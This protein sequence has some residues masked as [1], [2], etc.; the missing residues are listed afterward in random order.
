MFRL[1]SKRWFLRSD[2]EARQWNVE[3]GETYVC[4]LS[5]AVE[6]RSRRRWVLVTFSDSC[7]Q[8]HHYFACA[9][10]RS[11]AEDFLRRHH[12]ISGLQKKVYKMGGSAK[13]R[14]LANTNRIEE[15]SFDDAARHEFL[16][17]FHK[18]KLQRARH[19]QEIAE[20]KAKEEKRLER[21][22]VT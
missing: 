18:R 4:C 22:K 19:A 14:K 16:T 15:V 9:C 10:T 1:Y 12:T 11:I 7:P 5:E 21:K 17:G 6:L 13:K 3:C 2:E 20:K 8:I